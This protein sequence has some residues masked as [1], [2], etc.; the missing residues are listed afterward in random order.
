MNVRPS[1]GPGFPFSC[2]EGPLTKEML[3]LAL[4]SGLTVRQTRTEDGFPDDP[5][6]VRQLEVIRGL[7]RKADGAI[8]ATDTSREGAAGRPQP[9]WLS[10]LQGENR[11]PVAFL[12]DGRCDPRGVLRP[13]TGQSL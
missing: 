10:G 8:T 7:L 9:L 2:M 6:A 4:P 3:P 1:A 13:Q 11:T 5:V 12:A